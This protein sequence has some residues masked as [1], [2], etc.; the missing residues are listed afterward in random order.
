[1]QE[2]SIQEK[3]ENLNLQEKNYPLKDWSNIYIKPMSIRAF[4]VKI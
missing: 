3:I 4:K 2:K 1:M